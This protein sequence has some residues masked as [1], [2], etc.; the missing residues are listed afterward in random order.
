MKPIAL[1]SF[2]LI[3]LALA[4]GQPSNAPVDFAKAR[5]L[6]ERRQRGESLT[7]AEVAYLDQA[8]Q[9]RNAG[10]G[11]GGRA[12]N[13]RKAPEHLTPLTDLSA[14]ARYE[15][16]DGGLYGGGQNIPPAAHRR[17]AEAELAKI[18]PRNGTG[19]PDENGVIGFV[20]ISMSNATQEF[21][22][23]K[24]LADNS[25]LK[26]PQV[27]IV[28]CAQGGQAMAEWAPPTAR[29]WG[30]A[31]RRLAIANVSPLQVQAVWIKLAN[32]APAGSLAEHAHQLERDTLAVLQNARAMFPNLRI[33]Y[34]G[35]RTYGGY[36]GGGLNPEPYA[37]ESAF[38]ARWLIERQM[39]GDP[40]LAGGKCPILLWGP[41][42][43]AEGAKGRKI[44]HLIW[45]RSD[46]GPDGVHP[47]DSGRQKVAGLLLDFLT[48][49]S[50]TK[51]WFRKK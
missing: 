42:L 11:A 9:I 19:E 29:P 33:A 3:T 41:Y 27:V 40:E 13:Q 39:K 31:R 49:D 36:G 16:E 6:H 21:S 15:G 46:F 38:A 17:A 20:A 34:L 37:Y 43:W 44:D 10:A 50:L 23:F 22:R 1:I 28:D 5:L 47:S 12:L 18:R 51:P 2:L 4:Q 48:T 25:P 24:Q 35:S 7:S 14:S 30:E 26:S 45:E 32:K 8:I